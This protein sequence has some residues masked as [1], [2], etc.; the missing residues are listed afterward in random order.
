MQVVSNHERS[1]DMAKT[2]D[3]MNKN[4]R[5]AAK[6]L[7]RVAFVINKNTDADLIEW[8]DGD[9]IISKSE[10]V[11][12]AVKM[13]RTLTDDLKPKATYEADNG[14][15]FV[16][17]QNPIVSPQIEEKGTIKCKAVVQTQ[18]VQ[19]LSYY[20]EDGE[21]IATAGTHVHEKMGTVTEYLYT[22][23]VSGKTTND[24][25]TETLGYQE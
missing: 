9:N 10:I 8:L 20:T 4:E 6:N 17:I 12:L 23:R 13:F 16:Q 24:T 18:P 3:E 5:W 1:K 25:I 2:L 21:F 11:R 22:K 14:D 7:K 19:H 15:V